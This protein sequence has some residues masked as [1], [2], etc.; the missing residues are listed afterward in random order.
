[1][2]DTRAM[3]GAFRAK[4]GLST[5]FGRPKLVNAIASKAL[6]LLLRSRLASQQFTNAARRRGQTL[7]PSTDVAAARLASFLRQGFTKLSLGG[8]AKSLAG[9]VN[10]D[11][12][13]H[14]GVEREIVADITDLSFVPSGS[15][16]QVHSNHVV[17]HLEE[18]A[19]RRLLREVARILEPGGL[20]TMRAPNALG[21]CFGFFFGE[22]LEEDRSAFVELG[23]PADESFADPR[24]RWYGGDLFA[25]LHW[26]MGEPGR[27]DNQHL[28][29]LTPTACR[30]LLEE[31]GFDVTRMSEPEASNLVVVAR[32]R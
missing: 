3:S 2:V 9:F 6:F 15:I 26:L 4:S 16:S 22:V 18:A 30:R 32:K 24:D 19:T 27:I 29:I 10:V 23:F 8:G 20:L 28:Q 14:P 12:L 25:L 5:Y 1:M 11:F 7:S 13:E 31:S 21:V 17:E